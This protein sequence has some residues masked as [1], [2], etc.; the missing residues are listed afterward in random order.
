M[1]AEGEA[2]DGVGCERETAFLQLLFLEDSL[3]LEVRGLCFLFH[4]PHY[5]TRGVPVCSWG[6]RGSAK[7]SS[8]LKATQLAG[9][10]GAEGSSGSLVEK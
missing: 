5:P 2:W 4:L 8:L 9:E 3:A 6:N 1:R 7:L 10:A